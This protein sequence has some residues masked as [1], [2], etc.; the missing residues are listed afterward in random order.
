MIEILHKVSRKI[1]SILFFN[2]NLLYKRSF[3]KFKKRNL[4]PKVQSI[5]ETLLQVIE[6]KLSLARF[7][8]GEFVL[9]FNES[10]PF[11][12]KEITLSERLRSILLS[13]K[14]TNILICIVDIHLEMTTEYSL[15][16]WT[17]NT[18]RISK[19]LRKEN[20]FYGNANVF[21]G[22]NLEQFEILQKIWINRNVIFVVGLGSRFRFNNDL[23]K[24]VKQHEIIYGLAVNAWKDYAS[25]LENV[26]KAIEK[27]GK[28]TLV[29]T[30][31]GPTATVLAYDLSN[32]DIQCIDIG[33]ITNVYEHLLGK[34]DNP[35]SIP[36]VNK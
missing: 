3:N 32:K 2:S 25:I 8:D 9:C 29:L 6:N 22:L 13:K 24:G 12:E 15:R 36:L 20:S 33:H 16:F 31:L 23:F 28:D 34:G 10:I 35:E 26:S 17:L 7:G 19:L 14:K 5:D 4:Y 1:K 18:L 11:Q 27:M 21:R 30:S